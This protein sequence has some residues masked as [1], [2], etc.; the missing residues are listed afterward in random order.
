MD[1]EFAD[2]LGISRSCV[3]PYDTDRSTA[4]ALSE[5]RHISQYQRHSLQL[6]IMSFAYVAHTY[7]VWHIVMH[8]LLL[9]LHRRYHGKHLPGVEI[10]RTDTSHSSEQYAYE[11]HYPPDYP[12]TSGIVFLKFRADP[13]VSPE[14]WAKVTLCQTME[15]G[16]NVLRRLATLSYA[17]IKECAESN[18]FFRQEVRAFDDGDG[19]QCIS[20]RGAVWFVVDRIN[21]VENLAS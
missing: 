15:K 12:S 8:C 18:N 5:E 14:D 4:K 21:N 6:Q 7:R 1:V 3:R 16:Y 9:T 19:E 11:H 20:R 13:P 10:D 17:D 2:R